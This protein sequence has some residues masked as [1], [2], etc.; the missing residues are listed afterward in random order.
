MGGKHFSLTWGGAGGGCTFL[1]PIDMN[2]DL[3]EDIIMQ[4]GDPDAGF[5]GA[6]AGE[7]D[8]T[9]HS[10]GVPESFPNQGGGP[11]YV[12]D[13]NLDSRDDYVMGTAFSETLVALQTGGSKSCKPPS[14]AK[15]AAK[16]CTPLAGAS[17]A[18]PVLLQAAGNSPAGVIQLQ[19]WIDG[20]KRAVKWH[21]EMSRR[22]SLPSGT[23][24]IAVIAT[25]K[26][27][28]AKKTVIKVTVP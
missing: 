21:D 9:F 28:G 8:G 3:I 23:H 18:S 24:K 1:E 15:L 11:L 25:D 14:S 6:L 12:R 16:I 27:L 19:V 7:G 20:V 2:G 17:V 10:P 5:F 22:F 13:V 4:N 26:Y